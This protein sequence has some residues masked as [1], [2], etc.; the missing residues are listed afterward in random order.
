MLVAANRVITASAHRAQPAGSGRRESRLRPADRAAPGVCPTSQSR[1][2]TELPVF[3]AHLSDPRIA[4]D[5]ATIQ[6]LAEQYR[7]SLASDFLLVANAHLTWLGRSNWPG[8]GAP[9]WKLLTHG[10]SPDAHGHSALVSLS[11]GLYLV[12]L[13]PALFIDEVLGWLAAGYRLDDT[14]A[15]ELAQHHPRR[16]E[17]DRRMAACGRAASMRRRAR[18]VASLVKSGASGRSEWLQL[19]ELALLGA[20]VRAG[21]GRERD[22]RA[23]APAGEG[24][25]ADPGAA[26]PACRRGCC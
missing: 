11:D 10:A 22:G 6:A 17:P 25:A 16:R 2:I 20:R 14:F 26:R 15:R 7:Q 5:S 3:R 9:T 4:N 19:G 12:V 18:A 8:A 1:L 21:A 23:V 24:L 13:E